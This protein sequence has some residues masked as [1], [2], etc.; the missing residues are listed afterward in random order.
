M[1]DD[2]L[3]LLGLSK[4]TVPEEVAS[5]II[6][7]IA[8]VSGRLESK[9]SLRLGTKID[10]V[11]DELTGIVEEI[12]VQRYNRVGSE[13]MGSHTVEGES[14]TWASEDYFAPYESDIDEYVDAQKAA[15]RS[16]HIKFL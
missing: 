2:I 14:N 5:Q 12:C 8:I 1:Y 4:S 10:K 13:G 7:I 15:G 16:P 6:T 3:T 11:P 9:L